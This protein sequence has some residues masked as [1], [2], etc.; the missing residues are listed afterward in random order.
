LVNLFAGA[1]F[2]IAGALWDWT[3][4]FIENFVIVGLIVLVGIT[5]VLSG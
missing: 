1:C 4:S 2:A 5:V 3:G